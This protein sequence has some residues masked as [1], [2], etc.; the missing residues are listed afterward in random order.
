MTD[1]SAKYE[2][3]IQ[4]LRQDFRPQR[5]W[6]EGRG[7]FLV[8]GHFLVGSGG[9]R[10]AVRAAVRLSAR[11]DRG[12]FS[13]RWRRH[14]APR[15]SG[16]ARAL[17]EDGAA[18]PHRVDRARLR[19]SHLVPGGSRALPAAAADRG[20]AVGLRFR[21]LRARMADGGRRHG[22]ADRDIW[23]SSTP[24]RKASR[25]GTRR[26]IPSSIWPTHCAAAPPPCSPRWRCSV[27]PSED[28]AA[29]LLKL[30]IAIT[31]V[32]D[33]SV[34][35]RNSGGADRR[36]RRR[37][38]LGPRDVRRPCRG[39]FLRRHAAHRPGGP[40]DAGQRPHRAVELRRRWPQSACFRRSATSS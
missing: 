32:G 15:L 3:L 1:I 38:A 17:L 11:S 21:A 18:C 37:P 10:L 22:G 5:E 35:A 28:V 24:P 14:R 9:R 13:R 30:W 27:R 29:T 39:L 20:L 26:S 8:I 31:A 25:S 34:R 36:Q 6:G 40:A 19:R 4:D 33:R 16:S 2:K 23:A 12:I 7:V